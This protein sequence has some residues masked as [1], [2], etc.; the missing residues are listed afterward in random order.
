MNDP[1]EGS[2]ATK[3][4]GGQGGGSEFAAEPL[5]RQVQRL[6]AGVEGAA[7]TP[8]VEAG[9][10]NDTDTASERPLLSNEVIVPSCVQL[11]TGRQEEPLAAKTGKYQEREA[12]LIL[13]PHPADN[14]RVEAYV[15]DA[16]CASETAPGPGEL[17]LK[18]SYQRG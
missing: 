17:L 12:Y 16:S 7:A 4:T 13:L 3:H 2:V 8:K 15:V 1:A 6:L 18:R 5:D 11:G 9:T 14:G 10:D